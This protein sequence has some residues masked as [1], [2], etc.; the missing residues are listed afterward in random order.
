[1]YSPTIVSTCN[2]VN[3]YLGIYENKK[4]LY[5]LFFY[6]FPKL[7]FKKIQ[8]FKRIKQEKNENDELLTKIAVTKELSKREIKNYYSMLNSEES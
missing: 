7:P 3:K 2:V 4:D 5:S 8:Y 1:M 6:L